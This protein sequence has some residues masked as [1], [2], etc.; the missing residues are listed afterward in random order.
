MSNTF[1]FIQAIKGQAIKDMNDY[2]ILSSLTIA[3]AILESSWG[4]S[5]LSIKGNNLFGIKAG[6]NWEGEI[7]TYPT[8]EYVNGM[9][10]QINANFR[11][12]TSWAESI[13]DHTKLLLQP[14]YADIINDTDYKSVCNKIY[15]D[16]Y[17]T[18]PK[19]SEK[20]IAIIENY[21]LHEY[22][23]KFKVERLMIEMDT[24]QLQRW[25]NANGFTDENGNTLEVDGIEGKHTRAAVQKAKAILSYI[26]K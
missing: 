26:L 16:G 9:R 22:D 8:Y 21:Y 14:R 1:A 13:A 2:G 10:T 19:Y 24:K 20:L 12:Y 11:K 18:D 6:D 3:Q 17:A 7:I 4:E 23:L 25:L 5:S 15:Q